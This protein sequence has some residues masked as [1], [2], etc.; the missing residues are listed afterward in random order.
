MGH[1]IYQHSPPKNTSKQPP[2]IN[3]PLISGTPYPGPMPGKKSPTF[4]WCKNIQKTIYYPDLVITSP[5]NRVITSLH[6]YIQG[7]QQWWQQVGVCPHKRQHG[8][9]PKWKCYLL[10]HVQ[11]FVTPWTVALPGS[12]V[13]GN[14]PGKDTG[15]GFA[16]L[17]GIFLTQVLNPGLRH[18]RQILYRLRHKGDYNPTW[19]TAW[20]AQGG[21]C[22][23]NLSR[24]QKHVCRSGG[25][26]SSCWHRR[27]EP[28][29]PERPTLDARPL[30]AWIL[31]DR[32][33]SRSKTVLC[34]P[35]KKTLSG[36]FLWVQ[37]KEKR[38]T[39][40]DTRGW[41]G[42]LCYSSVHKAWERTRSCLT[43]PW[44]QMCFW[45]VPNQE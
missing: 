26:P 18:C 12:S 21:R 42:G 30:P 1:P 36:S 24:N 38:E 37:R 16:L 35:G 41:G 33:A 11:L 6:R 32:A 43:D 15:L 25:C 29:P 19:V 45:S 13:H 28:R 31:I 9:R 3:T 34:H 39:E 7:T 44:P 20:P 40:T 27:G 8:D 17:Q 10:S 5:Q 23:P 14:S 4:I 22:F 2:H